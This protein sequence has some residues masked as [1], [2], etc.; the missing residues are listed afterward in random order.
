MMCVKLKR[1]NKK[2]VLIE[3]RKVLDILRLKPLFPS[4]ARII[5][6]R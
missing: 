5:I 6:V 4:F 3:K 2:E 1:R